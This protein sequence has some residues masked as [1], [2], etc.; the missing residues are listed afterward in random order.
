MKRYDSI[1]IR[2][3]GLVFILLLLT[4]SILLIL[5]NNQMDN[6]FSQYLSNMSHMMGNSQ[7]GMGGMGGMHGTMHGPAESTYI[8]AVH[9]SLLWVGLGMIGVSVVVSYFVVREIMRPL[10]TLTGAVQKVR[11]GSYGQTV[12]V[13]RHD[14]VGVLT[15][16]FNEMSEELARNDKMRRQL[17]A[18]IAHELRT[19]LAILQGNLE[20]M[21]DDII[22]TDK[23][24]LL[25]M[26]D[27]TVRMGRLIQDLRDLSLAEINELTLHKEAA[28]I[29]VM[30]ERAV[31]MLQPLCDE[32]DL[33]VQLNLSRDLPS[34][35]IDI[36]R[37]NQ[38][39]YNLLNNAIR[40]IERGCAITVSTLPVRVDGK[41]Y[42]QVQIADTG[43][44]IAPK[45][46]EHIFQY[47]YR[48]E[49]SRNR[50]SGGSGIGLALAQQFIRS[51]GGN[52]WA[53]STVGKGTT[54]TF[55]LPLKE[56]D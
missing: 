46:L 40:Y 12:S 15:E 34:L 32:K 47:F 25:S 6:H 9:Q 30:L 33:T 37:I 3:T 41:S 52:I 48:S 36:D 11:T 22:P 13:E 53:D 27:E 24:I 16:S 31:S 17:F 55:I 1:V 4:I 49:Q 35:V 39:I 19:P 44:G 50:K 20:G 26:A 23:K 56:D 2:L 18:N 43:K 7:M 28:D 21:I 29:N 42:A 51:H 54:F 10:S 5:V 45:D 14:E 38:V 8:S